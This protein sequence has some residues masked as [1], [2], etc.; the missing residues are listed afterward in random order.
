MG[1]NEAASLIV[2]CDTGPLIHLD[3]IDSIGLLAEFRE[4]LVSEKVWEEAN[5]HRPSALRGE[6]VQFKRVKAP[7]FSQELQAVAKLLALHAGEQE[8]LCVAQA[9]PGCIFVTDDTAARLGA[10]MLGL[11]VHGTLGI[12]IRAVRQKQKSKEEVLMI[13]RSLP[14]KSSIHL[15]STL[16]FEIIQQVEK[17]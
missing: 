3:E 8:G 9:H 11:R 17:F 2:V 14:E 15:K 13:L 5:R 6:R 4:V 7:S 16:L 1:M 12:L 10:R